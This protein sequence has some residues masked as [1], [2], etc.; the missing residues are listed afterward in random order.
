L[1]NL[2]IGLLQ[3][4]EMVRLRVSGG[5]LRV[6]RLH[7]AACFFALPFSVAILVLRSLMIFCSAGVGP[8]AGL[9][10]V[11]VE[12]FTTPCVFNQSA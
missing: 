4:L 2:S 10:P 12:V 9:M 6:R 8:P 5:K 11:A 1:P 7:A 3:S